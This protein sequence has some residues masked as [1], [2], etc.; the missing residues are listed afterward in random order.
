VSLLF[1][2]IIFLIAAIVS[3]PI[4]KQLG[5]VS[6]LGYLAAGIVIGPFGLNL[7]GAPEHILD[8]AELGVVFLLFIIGLELQPSR[9]WVLRHMVFGLGGS[10]ILLSAAMIGLVAWIAG[11]A[12][13][14][15]LLVGLILAPS[16]TPFVLQLLAEKKQLTTSYGRGAFAILLMQDLAVV[17]LIAVIPLFGAGAA[18]RTG[19]SVNDVLLMLA[20]IAMLA[21][22]GRYLLKPV[23]RVVARTN[24]PEIFTATALLV[25]IG[26]AALMQLA[27]MSMVLGAFI[28]GMLLAR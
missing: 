15:A 25:V 7:V 18:Q 11:L 4:S 24:I 20:T 3:V 21:A 19:L 12:P 14:S 8:I 26:A 22:G 13:S 16:S 6:E 28:A 27:N 9:L 23:L 2:A 17:P 1:D 10:Q 5:F